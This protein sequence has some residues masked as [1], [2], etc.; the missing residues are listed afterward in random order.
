M[1][2]K[3]I[4]NITG[5]IVFAIA[6]ITYIA[7]VESTASLWDCSEFITSAFKLEVGHPPGAPLFMMLGH[8]FT[9]L[10][11]PDK[12]GLAI[13]IYSALC[14]AFTILFLFW[15]ITHLARRF[16][17]KKVS[18]YNVSETIM[19]MSCGIVG[20]LAYTFSDTFWFSAVEGEVY[21]AS[22]LITAL[23]F[24]T[25]LK[26]EEQS[27][28]EYANRWLVLIFYITG[29]SI[30]VH[31]LNLLVI[32]AIVFVY[33]LKK[34]EVTRNGIIATSLISVVIL[35]TVL[36]GVIPFAPKVASWFELMFVNSF[37]LPI[38][39]GV[40]FFIA[41][42]IAALCYGIYITR[43]NGK[44]LMNTIML[45]LSVCMLGYG[46]YA[47]IVIR[48]SANLPMDQNKPDN[49][50]SLIKYLNR[51][52]YG[53][54]PL[55]TGPYYN[56]TSASNIKN[57]ETYLRQD[58]KYVKADLVQTITYNKTTF[59]PRM[60]SPRPDHVR[61]YKRYVKGTNPTFTDNLHYFFDHQI[62]HMYFRYFMWNFVG[63]QNDYKGVNGDLTKG[64][65]ISGVKFIDES[66]LG[67]MDDMP[68][69]LSEN[70]GNNKYYFLPLILGLLGLFYQLKRDKKGFSIVML[71]FFFTGLAIILYLNQPP[72]EPRERDYV[73]AGSFYA[74][75]I[76]IG[77]GVAFI[78]K[79]LKKIMCAKI[80]API[81]LLLSL[82]VPAIMCQQNWDDHNRSGR[83]I[84]TDFGYNYLSSVEK[85]AILYTFGDNDTFT[86]WYNQEVEGVR[87]DVKVANTQYLHSDWYYA[88]MMRRTYDAPPIKTLAT[89]E[90]ILGI[91]KNMVLVA[92]QME[93]VNLKLAME[94]VMDDDEKTKYLD[95]NSGVEYDFFP[96]HNLRLPIDANEVI[97][98]GLVKDTAAL[99]PY[100]NF[101]IGGENKTEI[102]KAELAMLD[103][104]ANNYPQRPIYYG[105]NGGEFILG[106]ENNLRME[107]LA[108]RLVPEDVRISGAIDVEKS[109]DLIM[110]KYQYR[111]LNNPNVYHDETAR[112]T[113]FHY[114]SAFT[115][116]AEQLLETGDTD[117]LKQVML[118]Y[119]EVLPEIAILP[120]LSLSNPLVDFYLA[121]E[122]TDD[123]IS[124]A[125]RLIDEYRREF[126]Y[127][128]NKT[129]AP[130]NQTIYSVMQLNE[131]IKEHNQPELQKQVDDL[132]SE[133]NSVVKFQ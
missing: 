107:G 127:F 68:L 3:L 35:G 82:P 73:Y 93:N 103:F 48:S 12:A 36:W 123:G 92:N 6:A 11:S 7:T 76:W 51:D 55:L 98:L 18:E 97:E 111:G 77:F 5:W 117:K 29:L 94:F 37:G 72:V 46:S 121:S 69:Y 132:L 52:Q 4:N 110:N 113:M 124:L 22:S 112:S 30:G 99:L 60:Y 13:N 49:I 27:D 8:L 104:A 126:K 119:K 33:Y 34:Y 109:F 61:M 14:S 15:S 128:A 75:A 32:P 87:T 23:V 21:A 41:V 1:K 64:N 31:L 102:Y 44:V 78:F 80:A 125:Q 20:A 100:L 116:L 25:I 57:K 16:L 56:N 43:K 58:N 54:R 9:M 83:Y 2:Y 74:F 42:L 131:I 101:N 39:S 115:V 133:M 91:R 88:Q 62:N 122:L 38:N 95:P 118:K 10:V 129:G 114:Y 67:S 66:R 47:M 53:S 24:W 40:V 19:V 59:F 90:K 79:Y 130:I 106:L 96:S 71:L 84:A 17:S 120:Y 81:A 108:Y 85:N 105:S 86:L 26:W 70:K 50:F 45:C 28:T 65:W 89:P 63:R